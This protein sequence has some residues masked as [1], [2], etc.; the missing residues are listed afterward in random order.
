LNYGRRANNSFR[1]MGSSNVALSLGGCVANIQW[2]LY[3]GKN[4]RYANISE[5]VAGSGNTSGDSDC[6]A[7]PVVDADLSSD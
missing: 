1:V 7:I 3:S 2:R 6:Y 4:W 5:S